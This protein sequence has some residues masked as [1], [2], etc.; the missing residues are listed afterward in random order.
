MGHR[1]AIYVGDKIAFRT[2][3]PLLWACSSMFFLHKILLAK[4]SQFIG[5]RC[6]VR[7]RLRFFLILRTN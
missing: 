4:Q 1:F 2:I 3:D 5:A 6:L 7:C